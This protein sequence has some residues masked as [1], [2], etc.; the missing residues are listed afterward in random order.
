[1]F[2][3]LRKS[4]ESVDQLHPD[5][6]RTTQMQIC[7]LND[8]SVALLKSS[9]ALES[10]FQWTLSSSSFNKTALP[11]SE[12]KQSRFWYLDKMLRDDLN[13]Q[14]FFYCLLKDGVVQGQN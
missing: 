6:Y 4:G 10:L 7:P 1:M 14:S 2:R 5:G 3:Y 9:Q 12:G 13:T 8:V 11:N